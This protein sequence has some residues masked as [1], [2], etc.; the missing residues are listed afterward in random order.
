MV[1]G[2]RPLH[3]GEWVRDFF[4]LAEAGNLLHPAHRYGDHMIAVHLGN[5]SRVQ[6]SP[7]S[8]V[9]VWGIIRDVP[10]DPAGSTPLYSVEQ[11][12][13]RPADKSEIAKYFK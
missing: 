6:F 9:W 10:G 11:A 3:E 1:D 4:V 13:T 12:G 7:R 8:L 2:D 5:E